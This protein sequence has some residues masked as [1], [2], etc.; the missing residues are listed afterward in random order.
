MKFAEGSH[1]STGLCF[2]FCS[3]PSKAWQRAGMSECHILRAEQE[4]LQLTASFKTMVRMESTAFCQTRSYWVTASVRKWALYLFGHSLFLPWAEVIL[5]VEHMG[6]AKYT[7]E[8]W[9][10][11]S[12]QKVWAPSNVWPLPL[13]LSDQKIKKQSRG[14]AWWVSGQ[15]PW[16]LFQKTSFQNPRH[17]SE[18]SRTPMPDASNTLF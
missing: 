17:G 3:P 2:A 4:A 5:W 8:G 10:W 15:E 1:G 18:P 16:L 9:T 11:W 12:W 14:P 13:L 7:R 6:A